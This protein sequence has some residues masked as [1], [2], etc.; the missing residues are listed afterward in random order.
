VLN[1]DLQTAVQHVIQI[2]TT[3]QPPRA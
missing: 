2:L 3:Q 1:D